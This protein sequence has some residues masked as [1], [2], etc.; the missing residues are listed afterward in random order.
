MTAMKRNHPKDPLRGALKA[1][2]RGSRDAEI[3][4]YDHPLP[5]H[6]VHRSKRRYDR[7]SEKARLKRGEPFLLRVVRVVQMCGLRGVV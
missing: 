6:K 7:K 1:A 3:G 5:H 2:R 4:L